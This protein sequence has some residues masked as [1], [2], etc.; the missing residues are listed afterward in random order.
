MIAIYRP[1]TKSNQKNH[2]N[3]R[4]AADDATLTLNVL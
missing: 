4:D 1:L 2:E 3:A